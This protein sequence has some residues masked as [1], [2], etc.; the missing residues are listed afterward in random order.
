M[1]VDG[2]GMADEGER[3]GVG[4]GTHQTEGVDLWVVLLFTLLAKE[5]GDSYG[6]HCLYHMVL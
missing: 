6:V 1:L 5:A 3:G 4:E 2:V